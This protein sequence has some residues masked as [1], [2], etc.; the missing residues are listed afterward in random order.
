LKSITK[1]LINSLWDYHVEGEVIWFKSYSLKSIKD[2]TIMDE[3]CSYLIF[4][5][6]S[7]M[8]YCVFLLERDLSF[9]FC[10]VEYL[11]TKSIKTQQNKQ[12]QISIKTLK[13]HILIMNW[14]LT[15]LLYSLQFPKTM[16]LY[17]HKLVV[18][19]ISS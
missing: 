4:T 7:Y 13:L 1:V 9:P 5:I 15:Q 18:H 2:N 11:A 17:S 14:S 10:Y 19:T 8:N 6:W 3:C 16:K 12:Q